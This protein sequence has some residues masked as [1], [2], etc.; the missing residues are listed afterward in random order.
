LTSPQR[1]GELQINKSSKEKQNALSSPSKIRRIAWLRT[2]LTVLFM[3]YS[4]SRKKS[5]TKRTVREQFEFAHHLTI[6]N[7]S[8][9]ND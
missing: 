3:V 6:N 2:W 1:K 5:K 7:I 4:L 9:E 8:A